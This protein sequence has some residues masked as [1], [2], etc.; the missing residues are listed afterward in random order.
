MGGEA[1]ER[2]G[3]GGIPMTRE[4]QITSLRGALDWM[5][6]E[7]EVI[8]PE[9]D[10]VLEAG[11]IHKAFDDG[12]IFLAENLKG[13][14]HARMIMNFWG[15]QERLAR[16]LGLNSYKEVQLRMLEAVKNLIPPRVVENAPCHEVVI[17]HDE[18]AR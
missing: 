13:Y 15:R 4:E 14:P 8:E 3:R 5:K 1:T 18:V 17:P 12:P 2:I 10:P 6:D 7:L 9:V 16:L 11:A